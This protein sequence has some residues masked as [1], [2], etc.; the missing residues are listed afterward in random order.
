MTPT[1]IKEAWKSEANRAT[2]LGTWYHNQREADICG[3]D[4]M[5]RYGT[6]VPIF[7]PIEKEG[8]KIFSHSENR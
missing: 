4:N 3:L 1:E 5:E 7:K 6:T 8:I 2:S